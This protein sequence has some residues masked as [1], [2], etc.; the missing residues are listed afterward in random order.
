MKVARKVLAIAI[1]TG[2]PFAAQADEPGF[3]DRARTRGVERT[4]I[5]SVPSYPLLVP[6]CAET[7]DATLLK[8]APRTYARGDD[9]ATLNQLNTVPT[10]VTRPYPYLFS[11]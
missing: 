4:L 1:F 8:C 9:L 11:W 3:S 2:L 10:R 5:R 6:D 7:F